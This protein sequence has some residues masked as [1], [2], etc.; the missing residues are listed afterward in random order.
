[1]DYDSETAYVAPQTVQ[2]SLS[3]ASFG[4]AETCDTLAAEGRKKRNKTNKQTNKK[5]LRKAK[6]HFR[7]SLSG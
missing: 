5:R 4:L 1:M 3:S 7:Q 6:S 2:Q